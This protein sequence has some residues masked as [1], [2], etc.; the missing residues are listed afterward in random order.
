PLI[1]APRRAQLH[2]A[3]LH[4]SRV[5]EQSLPRVAHF[6]T[7]QTALPYPRQGTAFQGEEEA[8]KLSITIQ[9]PESLLTSSNDPSQP[10]GQRAREPPRQTVKE[11]TCFPRQ[12]IPYLHDGEPSHCGLCVVPSNC[13]AVLYSSNFPFAAADAVLPS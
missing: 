9:K 7:D 12:R 13:S 10:G 11:F 5:R 2:A 8:K 1:V 3:A 6:Q 4:S